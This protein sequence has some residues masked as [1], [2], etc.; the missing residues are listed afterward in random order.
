M[1][2]LR[3]LT[4][5]DLYELMLEREDLQVLD[6]RTPEEYAFGHI[7]GAVLAP[8]DEIVVWPAGLDPARPTAI[9]CKAGGRAM[10]AAAILDQLTDAELF[11]VG[12][13]GVGDWP[14]LGGDLISG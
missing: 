10:H 9:I 5:D 13:G 11:V 4:S 6:V 7:Q 3:V 8:Y 1:A 2:E 14:R 12:Q